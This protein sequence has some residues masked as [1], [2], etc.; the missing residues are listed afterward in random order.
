MFK[1]TTTPYLVKL[2]CTC[3]CARSRKVLV[4]VK[5]GKFVLFAKVQS[6]VK[7]CF[8]FRGESTDY[9]CHNI[10]VWYSE[11]QVLDFFTHNQSGELTLIEGNPQDLQN[12]IGS[13]LASCQLGHHHSQTE[14]AH[15]ES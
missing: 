2:L 14:W 1:L 3:R 11:M 7:V 5:T 12:Q 9:V 8:C 4:D 6:F 13:I 10:D 15:A